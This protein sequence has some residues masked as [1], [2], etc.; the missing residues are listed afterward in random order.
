MKTLCSTFLAA[1]FVVCLF[2][3]FERPAYGYVDPGSSLLIYQSITAMVAGAAFYLRNRI[4]SLF[5]GRRTRDVV[6]SKTGTAE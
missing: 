3:S 2:A 1:V 6:E 5:T 4:K